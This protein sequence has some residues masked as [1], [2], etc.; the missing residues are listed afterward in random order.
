MR[1]VKV[2]VFQKDRAFPLSLCNRP[3]SE[4]RSAVLSMAREDKIL[5]KVRC[6]FCQCKMGG[7]IMISKRDKAS[8][9]GGGDVAEGVEADGHSGARGRLHG[10]RCGHEGGGDHGG[11]RPDA[12]ARVE[13]G[14]GVVFVRGG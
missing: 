14:L 5:N 13:D 1:V 9:A 7:G 8:K 11:G 12:R 10:V 6:S 3:A 4:S 2:E